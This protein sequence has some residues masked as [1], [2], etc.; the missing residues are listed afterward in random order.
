MKRFRE[1]IADTRKR[2][3]AD[4]FFADFEK[5]CRLEPIRKKHYRSY[6]DALLLLD[7]ES[8]KRL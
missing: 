6:N 8:L 3:P 4:D 1:L 2:Y 5:S 7:S